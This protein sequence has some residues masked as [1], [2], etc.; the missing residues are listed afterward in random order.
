MFIGP[1]LGGRK[2][3]SAGKAKQLC[4]SSAPVLVGEDWLHQTVRLPFPPQ[5]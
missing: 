4:A 3:D 5:S 2:R 1:Q